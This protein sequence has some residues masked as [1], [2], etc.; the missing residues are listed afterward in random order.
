MSRTRC[1][2]GPGYAA[3]AG[4]G[5]LAA[6]L[7]LGLA[8]CD[9]ASGSLDDA[10]PLPSGQV[11]SEVDALRDLELS[12]LEAVVMN[13]MP[14]LQALYADDFE[15]VPPPGVV[16][17]RDEFLGALQDGGLD[18]LAWDPVSELDVRVQVDTAVVTYRAEVHLLAAGMG[19]L[20]HEMWQ[21]AVFERGDQGWRVVREQSTAVGGFPPPAPVSSAGQDGR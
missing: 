8:G 18:F 2:G 11:P 17:S 14:A 10:A 7:V 3:R 5:A 19:E 21:T 4:G 1:P 16:M 13:D 6:L 9:G 12:R 15:L 20:R